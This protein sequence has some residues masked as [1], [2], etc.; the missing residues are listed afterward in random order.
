MSKVLTIKVCYDRVISDRVD[1]Q[2]AKKE[3]DGDV[4]NDY[5]YVMDSLL[6]PDG[7]KEWTL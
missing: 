2:M 3:M 5:M 1:C 6:I 7:H 4:V